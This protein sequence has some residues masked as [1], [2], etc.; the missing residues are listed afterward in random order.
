MTQEQCQEAQDDNAGYC[1]QCDSLTNTEVEPET[2]NEECV[3]CGSDTVM[4]VET[5][6]VYGN[7]EISDETEEMDDNIISLN[8]NEEEDEG[9]N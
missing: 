8:D 6:L 3:E 9:W 4:G 5:A 2:N 7:I 1:S